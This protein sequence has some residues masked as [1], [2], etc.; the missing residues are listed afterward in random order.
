MHKALHTRYD[1][2]RLYV[3]RKEEGRRLASTEDRVDTSIRNL[4]S[5]HKAL[6]T[7]YDIGRLYVPRKEEGRRLASTEDRVDT[8]I[9]KLED[10]IKKEQRKTHYSDQ[11]QHRKH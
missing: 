3:P 2:G 1:I 7:R 11:K 5:M 9:R 10:Y 8:S 4:M 6:H